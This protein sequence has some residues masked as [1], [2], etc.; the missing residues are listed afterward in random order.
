MRTARHPRRG[1][2]LIE[3]LVVIAIIAVLIGLLLPAVQKVRA[4]AARMKCQNN[5]KQIG[6]ALHSHESA[7]GAFPNAYWR[8]TWAVDPTN[9]KGHFRWSALA[10]L[11]PYLEQTAV[12]NALDLTAPLYG[13][14]TLQ[15]EVIPFPQNRAPLAA[16]VPTFLCPSDEFRTVKEG[17]GPSNYVACVGSNAGGDALTGDGI[18]YGVDRDVVLNPGVRVAAVTDGLSNTVAFSESL[19]GAG[20]AAPAGGTDVR[21]YYKQVTALSQANCDAS[22]TLVTDR[23]ALWADGAYNCGLYNNVRTPNNPLMDCVQHSNPAWKAA[24]SRHSGG[25]NACLADGSVRF[26]SDGISQGT[27][28]AAGTRA[29]GEVLGSDW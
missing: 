20:G 11:T 24:R 2:T 10:Q 26:V 3:L 29:T 23:G 25:V 13:G 15:P 5:L 22:T 8:K 21:L 16:V 27:W 6:L 17:Q 7:T 9:P 28:A 18:F 12:Y 4:A 19:L 1:F 14:G